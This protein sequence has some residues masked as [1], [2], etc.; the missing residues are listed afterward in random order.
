MFHQFAVFS[1]NAIFYC[2]F[3]IWLELWPTLLDTAPNVSCWYFYFWSLSMSLNVN[4][5]T[6]QS[7]QKALFIS[8]CV[9]GKRHGLALTLKN[10]RTRIWDRSMP[11]FGLRKRE[12]S[13]L[14]HHWCRNCCGSPPLT[15]SCLKETGEGA[16]INHVEHEQKGSKD[17]MRI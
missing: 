8:V 11:I 6:T 7:R 12:Y 14:S 1:K 2:V 5:L 16:Q 9:S 15:Q 3:M 4:K 13:P 17:M 10:V